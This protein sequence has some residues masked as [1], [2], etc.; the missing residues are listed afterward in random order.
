MLKDGEYI[1]DLSYINRPIRDIV[2]VDFEDDLLKYHKTNAI[3]IPKFEGDVDD[4]ALGDLA[5]FLICKYILPYF[6]D[7][8]SCKGDIREEIKLHGGQFDCYKN[9]AAKQ[10]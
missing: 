10:Q 4:Q 3:V 7:L 2:Y 1:K 6:L 9:Y 8:S 5:P